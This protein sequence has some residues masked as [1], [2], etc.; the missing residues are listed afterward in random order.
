MNESSPPAPG[1]ASTIPPAED[2]YTATPDD[3][4]T[5][6]KE[7]ESDVEMA[8][9]TK[10]GRPIIVVTPDGPSPKA[11][12]GGHP[13]DHDDTTKG[14]APVDPITKDAIKP[15]VAGPS[16]HQFLETREVPEPDDNVQIGP[17]GHVLKAPD[18]LGP[19]FDMTPPLK[20]ML[21]LQIGILVQS[22]KRY[23]FKIDKKYLA[24]SNKKPDNEDPLNL[25][26]S[27]LKDLILKEWRKGTPSFSP[28]RRGMHPSYPKN[29][30]TKADL[31]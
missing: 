27:D 10:D 1:G 23:D 21:P 31:T 12:L 6:T 4:N 9:M 24:K 14:K 16:D 26:V 5:T 22:G 3:I 28:L 25:T 29:C 7:G 8:A 20:I 18:P 15:V 30:R 17:R 11:P 19:E 2:T 13:V